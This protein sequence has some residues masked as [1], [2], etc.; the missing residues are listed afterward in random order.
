MKFIDARPGRPDALPTHAT[1]RWATRSPTLTKGFVVH[2]TAGSNDDPRV[3]ARYHVGASHTS[4]DGMA[5]LAYTFYIRRNGDVWWANDLDKRTWS[6]G[7]GALHPDVNGDGKIDGADGLGNANAEFVAIVVAGSFDSRWNRTGTEPTARQIAALLLLIS[8]LTGEA[9]W[10]DAHAALFD[11]LPHLTIGDVWGHAHFGKAACPG[12]RL[13]TLTDWLR[14]DRTPLRGIEDWQRA[15]VAK[16]HNLG[17]FGPTRNGV[18][19]K[20]GPS[21]ANA[22]RSFQRANGLAP[23]GDRDAVTE[24]AL[25]A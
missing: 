16:G 8:H 6:Q 12:D 13:L 23:T 17:T 20:W 14:E 1:K 2:H 24:R 10:G 19:G 4:P 18:D 22:L 11:S 25:F 7:G 9:I 3:T 21:S 5:G 15:L